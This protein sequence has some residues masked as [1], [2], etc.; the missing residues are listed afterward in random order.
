MVGILVTGR[1]VSS[2]ICILEVLGLMMLDAGRIAQPSNVPV[3]PQASAPVASLVKKAGQLDRGHSPFQR[4]HQQKISAE[5]HLE[6][7][8]PM[9]VSISQT[10]L[11]MRASF[12]KMNAVDTV[13]HK[14][15]A[16]RRYVGSDGQATVTVVKQESDLPNT[17]QSPS[18]SLPQQSNSY[19]CNSLSVYVQASIPVEVFGRYDSPEF[20]LSLRPSPQHSFFTSNYINPSPFSKASKASVPGLRQSAETRTEWSSIQVKVEGSPYEQAPEPP[21]PAPMAQQSAEVPAQ[22]VYYSTGGEMPTLN[23]LTGDGEGWTNS[24]GGA[25]DVGGSGSGGSGDGG[26]GQDGSGIGSGGSG[27]G[28]DGDNKGRGNGAGGKGKKLALACHFCR[29][30]KLK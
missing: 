7:S 19:P 25:G 18:Q 10:P 1:T 22:G 8:A 13:F 12:I 6:S 27:N 30:R 11:Q 24:D 9:T 2:C 28:D 3:S 14:G 23:G 5:Q 20:P 21:L 15:F 16:S 17:S 26:M 4:L 29:R